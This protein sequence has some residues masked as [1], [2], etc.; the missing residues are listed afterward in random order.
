MPYE[1]CL[2]T[3]EIGAMDYFPFY[4]LHGNDAREVALRTD[5]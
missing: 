3:L 4:A 2:P 1:S 5:E